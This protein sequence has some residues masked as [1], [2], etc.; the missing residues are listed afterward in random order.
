[1][2]TLSSCCTTTN[3]NFTP[4]QRK[5]DMLAKYQKTYW[6]YEYPD[7]NAHFLDLY[8]AF[9]VFYVDTGIPINE[10]MIIMYFGKPD[11]VFKKDGYLIFAYKV[12]DYRTTFIIILKDNAI[13]VMRVRDNNK[14]L[15][16]Q[17]FNN[18]NSVPVTESELD[19]I[20]LKDKTNKK[21]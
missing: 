14:A 12:K 7:R 6:T 21:Q 19:K 13:Q 16:E 11:T 18:K 8:V 2:L 15:L 9:S 10:K 4:L 1:M 20:I 3:E 17:I 5:Y